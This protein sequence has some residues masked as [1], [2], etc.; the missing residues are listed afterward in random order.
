M[1]SGALGQLSLADRALSTLD[2]G[3]IGHIIESAST[4]GHLKALIGTIIVNIDDSADFS[5][6]K[7]VNKDAEVDALCLLMLWT[8]ADSQ[9]TERMILLASD[10][11]FH[12]RRLG[13]GSKLYAAQFGLMN[14][15]EKAREAMGVSAWRKCIFLTEYIDRVI[16]EGRFHEVKAQGER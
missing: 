6:F 9:A 1:F 5:N 14:S 16:G 11:V 4:D 7:R 12:G 3:K 13:T 2:S 8:S 15:E 10:L